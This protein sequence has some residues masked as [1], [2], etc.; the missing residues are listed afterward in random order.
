MQFKRMEQTL[1]ARR[2]RTGDEATDRLRARVAEEY[3][4]FRRSLE[5]WAKVRDQWVSDRKQRLLQR[6]EETSFRL[7]LKQI[8]HGLRLQRR[9]LRAMTK[10]SLAT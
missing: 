5:E 4:A 1:E 2:N 3:A 7:Q 10:A 6:W 9:R 8:E